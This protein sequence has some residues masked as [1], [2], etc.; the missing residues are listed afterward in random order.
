MQEHHRVQAGTSTPSDRQRA[1]VRMRALA[2]PESS[3][4]ASPGAGL[5]SQRVEGAVDV[6][7]IA[8]EMSPSSSASFVGDVR[9]TS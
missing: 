5:R 7:D 8:A 4:A 6:V 2:G 3:L 9:W 1:L